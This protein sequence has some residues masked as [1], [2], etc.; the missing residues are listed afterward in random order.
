MSCTFLEFFLTARKIQRDTS[1]IWIL[2][3]LTRF[4]WFILN[5]RMVSIMLKFVVKY[6]YQRASYNN[7]QKRNIIP[8]SKCIIRK[9][10]TDWFSSIWQQKKKRWNEYSYFRKKKKKIIQFWVFSLPLRNA[11]SLNF[12]KPWALPRSAD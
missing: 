9:M 8:A 4:L 2:T 12:V 1:T 11:E 7:F 10:E 5:T 3:V 6:A